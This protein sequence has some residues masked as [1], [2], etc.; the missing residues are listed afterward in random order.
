MFWKKKKRLHDK[1]IDKIKYEALQMMVETILPIL[2]EWM[3]ENKIQYKG[4]KSS[5]ERYILFNLEGRDI[6]IVFY[7]LVIYPAD[8]E[9]LISDFYFPVDK[10]EFGSSSSRDKRV[11]NIYDIE[12]IAHPVP[13]VP[14]LDS[15]ISDH[16]PS[17]EELF[18]DYAKKL[19]EL[20]PHCLDY[21]REHEPKKPN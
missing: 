15:R 1:S 10:M 9:L 21:V 2:D 19:M 13:E 16:I 12:R 4:D 20:Y 3:H 6:Q 7:Y 18:I 11:A 17:R 8:I 14:T 5:D